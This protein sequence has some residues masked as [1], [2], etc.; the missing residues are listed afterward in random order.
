MLDQKLELPD[1]LGSV[2][3]GFNSICLLLR[4]GYFQ[5]FVFILV[6]TNGRRSGL[7]EL[8]KKIIIQS[9]TELHE[10]VQDQAWQLG[11]F[12]LGEW[13]GITLPDLLNT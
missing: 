5:L 1:N 13:N 7:T 8:I 11:L 4:Q 6:V 3:D 12:V 9:K 2:F 10:A